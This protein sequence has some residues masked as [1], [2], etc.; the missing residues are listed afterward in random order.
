MSSTRCAGLSKRSRGACDERG[1]DQY[2]L[3]LGSRRAAA[4]KEYLVEQGIDAGRLDEVSTGE[5]SP[6]DPAR[7]EAAW[8]RNRRAEFQIV[9]GGGALTAPIASR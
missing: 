2:N 1:S 3:A 4:A 7:N 9:S 5:G 6:I 8:V